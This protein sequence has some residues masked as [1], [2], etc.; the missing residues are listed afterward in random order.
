M[1]YLLA[2]MHPG[3]CREATEA[4]LSLPLLLFRVGTNDTAR[5]DLGS[6]KRDYRALGE[7]V[8]GMGA[9]VVLSS[10]LLVRWMGLR[11]T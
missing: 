10:I 6:M 3:C 2:D 5:G 9:Q 7:V 1:Y 8:K 11:R 4:H